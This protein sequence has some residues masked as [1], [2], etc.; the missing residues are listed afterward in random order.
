MEG[1]CL[2]LVPQLEPVTTEPLKLMTVTKT[3][4]FE[5]MTDRYSFDFKHCSCDKGF[6]QLDTDQDASY[7]GQW[8]NPFKRQIVS[9]AEGDVTVINADTDDE[10]IAEMKRISKWHKDYGE[11][12][13]I[14]PGLNP[15]HKYKWVSL[16]LSDLLH[17]SLGER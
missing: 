1:N 6:S 4:T 5:P 12:F 14:D 11:S 8:A 16:G 9:Y 15:D 3:D 17:K 7:Y 13:N 2:P 10:F